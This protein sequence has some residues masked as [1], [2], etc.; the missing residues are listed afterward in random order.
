MFEA[1]TAW[2]RSWAA[3]RADPSAWVDELV[4]WIYGSSSR[5]NDHPHIADLV[6]TAGDLSFAR[7]AVADYVTDI[8]VADRSTEG[9]FEVA[10][11]SEH[12][13]YGPLLETGALRFATMYLY[14]ATCG[15]CGESYLTCD[16]S[17]YL[18]PAAKPIVQD[19]KL[20]GLFW[21]E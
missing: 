9:G 18:D 15:R 2:E 11:R 10:L 16:C 13:D 21:T 17:R 12:R 6:R 1:L 20:L 14:G 4:T 3:G 5:A 19:R 8:R 7:R